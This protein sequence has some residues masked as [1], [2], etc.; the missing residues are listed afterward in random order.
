MNSLNGTEKSDARR[1]VEAAAWRAHLAEANQESTSAF[2]TWLTAHEGNRQAWDRVRQTWDLFGEQATSPELLDLRRR[3]LGQVRVMSRQRWLARPSVDRSRWVAIAASLMVLSVFGIA[4][5]YFLGADTYRT[6]A[7]ERRVVTLSDG[8][9]IQLDSLTELSVDYSKRA[10]ELKLTKGQ[11][12]FDVAHDVERPFSV[13]AA[14][15]K[16]IATGTA[17]NIDLFNRNLLVTLI[18]GKIAILP[19]ASAIPRAATATESKAQPSNAKP[20]DAPAKIAPAARVVELEAGQRFAVSESG[21]IRVEPANVQQA[22]AWQSGQLVF[23]NEPLSSVIARVN[24]YAMH[25]VIMA[26]ET[27]A[28]LH[29]SGVFNTRD[30]DG[31]ISTITHYL[32]IK[33]EQS[34]DVIQLSSMAPGNRDIA[35]AP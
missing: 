34:G 14:G 17:F 28:S 1:L 31:F 12:R 4:T 9:K 33:A 10:R 25:S 21:A 13:L 8:S 22:T 3:A 30:V 2:E 18:E 15:R 29:I 20:S 24:R 23:E 16:V 11:A 19:Q 32:P 35:T 5:L 26:D 7:G 6:A 27:V